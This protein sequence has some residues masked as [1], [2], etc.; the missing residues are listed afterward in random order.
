MSTDPSHRFA[1]AGDLGLAVLRIVVGITFLAHGWQKVF[2]LGFG[3]V[4]DGFTKGGVPLPGVTGPLVSLTELLGGIA[5]ILGLLTR[6]AALGVGIVMLGAIVIVH[7]KAGFFLPRGM[8]FT[9]VLWAAAFAL[10]LNGAGALSLDHAISR[11]RAARA[12]D[13]A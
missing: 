13:G 9:L 4:I 7:A 11:R 2:V 3:G 8:E 6:L 1:W 12:R 10:S 5:L